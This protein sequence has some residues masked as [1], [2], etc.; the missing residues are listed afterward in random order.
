MIFPAAVTIVA[1]SLTSGCA[2]I[3]SRGLVQDDQGQVLPAASVRVSSV[4]NAGTVFA[5]GTDM[6]GCFLVSKSPP[7]GERH[8]RLEITA[9]G[10]Q[11]ATFDFDLE[12]PILI[13]TLARTGSGSQ[14]GIHPA[15]E[16]ERED[17]W[18]AYCN[19][20]FPPGAQTLGP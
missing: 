10:Y 19:P 11:P 9:S 8:F 4:A 3:W 14:S 17:R 7:K 18:E 6:F 13:A 2:S 5:A 20:K 15:T 16:A 12:T 1:A